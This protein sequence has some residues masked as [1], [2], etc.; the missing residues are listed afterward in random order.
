V[1]LDLPEPDPQAT[2]IEAKALK[3]AIQGV[4]VV[5]KAT[6][7]VLHERKVGDPQ[8]VRIEVTEPTEAIPVVVVVFLM[9]VE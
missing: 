8:E 4:V 5:D 1:D 7:V 3:A 9:M 6:M 2:R